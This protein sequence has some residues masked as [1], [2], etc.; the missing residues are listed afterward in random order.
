MPLTTVPFDPSQHACATKRT[1]YTHT[2][3]CCSFYHLRSCDSVTAVRTV[4]RMLCTSF[5]HFTCQLPTVATDRGY[6]SRFALPASNSIGKIASI[7]IH[8]CR[9]TQRITT[10]CTK[11][12]PT[13][14]NRND[15]SCVSHVPVVY[16]TSSF[17]HTS[18]S[19]MYMLTRVAD[20]ERACL[21]SPRLHI[22]LVCYFEK[23]KAKQYAVML[24]PAHTKL[25]LTH[26]HT[27]NSMWNKSSSFRTRKKNPFIVCELRS[28]FLVVFVRLFAPSFRLNAI[29]YLIKPIP[30]SEM[31]IDMGNAN[32]N[33]NHT[34]CLTLCPC[35]FLRRHP[36]SLSF[37]HLWFDL[38]HRYLL[39]L[40]TSG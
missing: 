23:Y 27:G 29:L 40:I 19:Y 34:N 22:H 1:R 6:S 21:Y 32:K 15:S 38:M 4:D 20:S 30:M 18:H 35:A 14:Y 3:I 17:K 2:H 7:N 26:T 24:T 36:S 5:D 11:K 25:K 28:L 9:P 37:H 8:I 10:S 13:K 39:H 31:M 33:N 16:C 12:T